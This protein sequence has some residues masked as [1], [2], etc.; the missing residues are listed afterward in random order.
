MSKTS[1]E[2]NLTKEQRQ[3]VILLTDEA[4]DF[5]TKQLNHPFPKVNVKF[6]LI[7]KAAGMYVNKYN[8]KNIRY[9]PFIFAKYFSE[10]IESTI[11]HE[12][13]H[14]LVDCVYGMKNTKP[15]GKEWKAVMRMFK[16]D[17]SVYCNFDISDLPQRQYKTIQ[18]QCRCRIHALTKIRHNRIKKGYRYHCR[19]CKTLLTEIA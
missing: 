8:E 3:Q 11:P 17:A 15:H 14:Y 9:N 1:L 4:I 19:F 18:Y 5:A 10:N 13:A 16:A 7:G 2:N 12:V 6:D